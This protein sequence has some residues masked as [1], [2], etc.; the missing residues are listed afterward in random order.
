M[1]LLAKAGRGSWGSASKCYEAWGQ[2]KSSLHAPCAKMLLRES[3]TESSVGIASNSGCTQAIALQEPIDPQLD[4][5]NGLIGDAPP[6]VCVVISYYDARPSE[7]LV[8]LMDQ[9]ASVPAGVPFRARIVVNQEVMAPLE[10]PARHAEIPILYRKNVGFNIGAWEA[11]WRASPRFAMYTFLQDDCYIKRAGWL[12]AYVHR[13]RQASVGL[14]GESMSGW[15]KWREVESDP[16]FFGRRPN[17]EVAS[18]GRAEQLKT[19]YAFFERNGIDQG[20]SSRHLQS[21]VLAARR[22]TLERIGGFP[23]GLSYHEAVAAEIGISKRVES[24][25]LLLRQAAWLPFTFVGHAQWRSSTLKRGARAIINPLVP[26]TLR[27]FLR[28]FMRGTS[29]TPSQ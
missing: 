25:G 13:L 27:P 7:Q 6:P 9:I 21:L 22:E 12:A 26:S 16:L 8:A 18:G 10:L 20:L 1:T 5:S 14:V 23:I 15:A 29:A 3:P 11:G 2:R 24:E 4:R 28:R 17:H 19:M